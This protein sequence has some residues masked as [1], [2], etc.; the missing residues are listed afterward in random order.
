[1]NNVRN[2]L[3]ETDFQI[4]SVTNT[5]VHY[6]DLTCHVGRSLEVF[7]GGSYFS[8]FWFVAEPE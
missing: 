8:L 2:I 7:F 6:E 5:L 3:L 1:M 4:Q